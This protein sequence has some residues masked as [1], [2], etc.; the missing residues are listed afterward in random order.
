MLVRRR[1]AYISPSALRPNMASIPG[2][3]TWVPPLIGLTPVPVADETDP[4]P[5]I[6]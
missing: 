6:D 5:V 4:A 3:G 2:S 1:R